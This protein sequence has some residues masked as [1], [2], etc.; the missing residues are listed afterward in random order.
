MSEDYR[1]DGALDQL[2]Q[3]LENPSK[4]SYSRLEA[5][6]PVLKGASPAAGIRTASLE[7]ELL[8]QSHPGWRFPAEET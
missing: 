4:R 7:V 3:L 1:W 6:S 8:Y 2:M 5:N